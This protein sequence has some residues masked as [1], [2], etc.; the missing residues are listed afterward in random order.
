MTPRDENPAGIHLPLDPLPGHSSR[1]R[2]ER[3]AGLARRY[4]AALIVGTIDER[5]MAVT[6]ER[7][8]EIARR[9]YEI[10]TEELD[11][12][13]EDIWWD[14]L[15]FP[16]GTGDENYIG[17][18][19]MTVEGVRAIKAEYPLTKTVLG[20]SNVSFGLPTAGREVLNS[21]FLYHATR[22]GLVCS[23][24]VS[25]ARHPGRAEGRRLGV[26]VSLP[27]RSPPPD[28]SSP[29]TSRSIVP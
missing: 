21:V 14:A 26:F 24:S 10:L 11:I 27:R 2:L 9:S 1:G 23:Y 25:T 22:A 16:C 18:A 3:V 4:G 17:S 13:P 6:V 28:R 20:V 7:K 8:L 19:A 15:V 29:R 12:P 5:G